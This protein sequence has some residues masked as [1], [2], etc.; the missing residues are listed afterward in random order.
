MRIAVKQAYTLTINEVIAPRRFWR[1][2]TIC[3]GVRVMSKM[4][5][6]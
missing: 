3:G 2:P 5:V 6:T 4:E 1:T